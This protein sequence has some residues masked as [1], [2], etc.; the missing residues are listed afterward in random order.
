MTGT[1]GVFK[2]WRYNLS[3]SKTNWNPQADLGNKQK[4][5][6]QATHSLVSSL[7]RLLF[8]LPRKQTVGI[9]VTLCAQ[10]IRLQP[11]LPLWPWWLTLSRRAGLW[12]CKK[13]Q[14]AWASTVTDSANAGLGTSGVLTLF[15]TP[16]CPKQW[17][18]ITSFNSVGLCCTSR[19][20][21][22]GNIQTH[23]MISSHVCI[24]LT[25]YGGNIVVHIFWVFFLMSSF[26]IFI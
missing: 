17:L 1:W 22:F 12:M 15:V 21:R 10:P 9:E 5:G 18:R 14:T 26:Q 2:P 4:N 25:F 16:G 11:F 7:T 20:E 3:P 19:W 13:I 24:H 6:K 23:Y 8:P